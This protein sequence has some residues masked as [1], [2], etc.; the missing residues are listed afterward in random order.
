MLMIDPPPSAAISAPKTCVTWK[1]PSRF[2]STMRRNESI[3][4]SGS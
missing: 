4:R 2:T 3:G 1:V